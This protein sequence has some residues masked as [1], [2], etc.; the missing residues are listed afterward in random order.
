MLHLVSGTNKQGLPRA[1]RKAWQD[2]E[3]ENEPV[4]S[5]FS[6]F[7]KKISFEF[8][9]SK[10]LELIQ[11][12]QSFRKLFRG[13]YIYAVDGNEAT[14]PLS[15]E[16]LES[17]YR[18][19]GRLNKSETYYPRVYL[20]Q[21]FDVVNEITVGC[22]INQ[23]RNENRD[24]LELIRQMEK[25]SV[26]LYDRAYL[27]KSLLEAHLEQGNF[28]VFRCRSGGTFKEVRDF[29]KSK[30]RQ[31]EWIYNGMVIRLIKIKI[32]GSKE[33]LVLATNLKTSRLRNKEIVQLYLRRWSIETSIGDAAKQGFGQWH[34][35]SENGIFQEI[36]ARLWL[37]NL[38]RL[39]LMIEQPRV[40]NWLEASY[41][42]ANLKLLVELLVECVPLILRKRF[43]Q[44]VGQINEL[45]RRTLQK[46][47]RLSRRYPRQLRSSQN[48]NYFHSNVVPRRP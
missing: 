13:F 2:S 20:S 12:T 36:F 7:R 44:V 37:I 3:L 35:K 6:K 29:Y 16:I 4:K 30:A 31:A 9:K 25:N 17:G 14:L 40:E 47:K 11:S 10:Y 33:L 18:G 39:Q 22:T 45:V 5:S 8:F 38:A 32:P 24:A 46:R 15:N 19:R 48:T 41:K 26:A 21:M 23:E 27:S 43:R 34:A 1:L 28:F 42:K